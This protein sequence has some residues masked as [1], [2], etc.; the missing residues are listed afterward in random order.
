[1]REKRFL[2]DVPDT[3]DSS[4]EDQNCTTKMPDQP[5]EVHTS[6]EDSPVTEIKK[7]ADGRIEDLD[8]NTDNS[9][10]IKIMNFFHYAQVIYYL[11]TVWWKQE[12]HERQ[13]VILF[14]GRFLVRLQAS[15]LYCCPIKKD[16]EEIHLHDKNLNYAKLKPSKE[17]AKNYSETIW[18]Y[19]MGNHD[20]VKSYALMPQDAIT[21]CAVLFSEVIRYPCMF[22]H[23]ILMMEH[24][25][26][27]SEFRF[28]HPMVT[29][30]SWKHQSKEVPEKVVKREQDNL[31]LCAKK[32]MSD[33]GKRGTLFQVTSPVRR[34]RTFGE[35]SH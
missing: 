8:L 12:K 1:M 28:Y 35:H 18:N 15:D 14:V 9:A 10:P 33:E 30:G 23:N 6:W 7:T 21:V 32:I 27:W 31:V 2:Y 3:S 26:S 29:G 11:I 22:F 20:K 4:S 34:T 5:F 16:E 17:M 25:K 13:D 24:Y 19:I